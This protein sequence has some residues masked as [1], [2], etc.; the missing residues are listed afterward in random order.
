MS[1]G[2][3]FSLMEKHVKLEFVEEICKKVEFG[4]SYTFSIFVKDIKD[5]DWCVIETFKLVMYE[6]K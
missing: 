2:E 1:L 5:Y 6:N 4:K 3:F